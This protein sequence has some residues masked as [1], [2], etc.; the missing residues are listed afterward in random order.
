MIKINSC[1]DIRKLLSEKEFDS[2][3]IKN[4]MECFLKSCS[5]NIDDESKCNDKKCDIEY[6]DYYN[7]LGTTSSS[8]QY[9]RNISINGEYDDLKFV[10][11]LTYNIDTTKNEIRN[12]PFMI[13]LNKNYDDSIYCL[14]MESIDFYNGRNN[15]RVVF[16]IYKKS[17]NNFKLVI[18]RCFYSNI[19]DFDKVLR[20]VKSFVNNP[21]SVFKICNDIMIR[22]MKSK[23]TNNDIKKFSIKEDNSSKLLIK[24]KKKVKLL[25]NND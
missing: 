11:T 16:N 4:R 20:I 25:I 21:E 15:R 23:F 10:F 12:I 9:N 8:V 2:E 3:I 13:H 1:D 24:L 17:R 5:I 14:K 6:V 22:D 19:S 18:H 7:E